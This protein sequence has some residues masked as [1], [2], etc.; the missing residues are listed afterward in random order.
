[1]DSLAIS[2]LY[3]WP[4]KHTTAVRSQPNHTCAGVSFFCPGKSYSFLGLGTLLGLIGIVLF[5]DP[6][7]GDVLTG[8]VLDLEGV[9][10]PVR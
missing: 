8:T 6:S 10:G 9:I 5:G 1:M 2:L 4:G 3:I 7:P